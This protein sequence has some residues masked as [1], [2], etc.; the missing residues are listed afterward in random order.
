MRTQEDTESHMRTQEDTGGHR[1]SQE[2]TESHM[3][4]HED[5]GGHRRSHEDTGGDLT[6]VCALVTS[7]GNAGLRKGALCFSRD[8]RTFSMK[9]ETTTLITIITY[10]S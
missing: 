5:K 1:R 7:S 9:L 10:G 2:V 6:A 4:S 8:P 3:R